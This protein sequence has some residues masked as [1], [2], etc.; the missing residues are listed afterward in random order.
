[1]TNAR[2]EAPIDGVLSMTDAAPQ[3]G[4]VVLAPQ[5]DGGCLLAQH[6]GGWQIAFASHDDA[7]RHAARYATSIGRRIWMRTVD[8]G[9]ARV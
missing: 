1:M 2:F 9:Y 8:N 3:P 4:D 5:A 6:P 7:A